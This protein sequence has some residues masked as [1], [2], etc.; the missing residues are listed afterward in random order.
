VDALVHDLNLA[1]GITTPAA[2]E[3]SPV[4][5]TGMAGHHRGP[6][7]PA[8]APVVEVDVREDLR[9]GR[10]PFARIMS[11]VSALGDG[12]VLRVRAIFQPAPLLAVLAR[13]GFASESDE[14]APDDWSVWFWRDSP[15][16]PTDPAG[17][18]SADPSTSAAPGVSPRTSETSGVSPRT[19]EASVGASLFPDNHT[20]WLDVRGL[21]PPDPLVRTLAALDAL[22]DGQQL[23]HVNERVPQLLLPM[24]AERGFACELDVSRADRVLLRIW[25]PA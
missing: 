21:Q 8:G 23:I 12:E 22:P 17:I 13:R 7:R 9:Q 4:S 15:A 10:E 6:T 11:A 16:P 25:R 2:D 3:A 18:A 1:L 5:A 20:V 14:H 19:S 24:L